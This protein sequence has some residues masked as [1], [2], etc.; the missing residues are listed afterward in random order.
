[1]LVGKAFDLGAESSSG[2]CG[3]CSPTPCENCFVSSTYSHKKCYK[4]L[5]VQ[6]GKSDDES[7]PCHIC[8]RILR[9]SD[10]IR[11]RRKLRQMKRDRNNKREARGSM[12]PILLSSSSAESD[13][14]KRIN[15]VK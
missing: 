5:R 1:M 9:G 2:D 15:F 4:H 14:D 10:G 6:R 12:V 8:R 13:D 3:T 11:Y 7:N